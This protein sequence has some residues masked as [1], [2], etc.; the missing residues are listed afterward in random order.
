VALF[1][2]QLEAAECPPVV[3]LQEIDPRLL[4]LLRDE[5]PARCESAYEIVWH[6]DEGIDRELVLTTYEVVDQR[7]MRLAGPLRSAYRVRLRAPIGEIVLVVTHLASSDNTP[8]SRRWCPPP[9]DLGARI[10]VCQARQV[11]DLADEGD[12]RRRFTAVAGDLNDVATSDALGVFLDRGFVDTH[13]AAGNVECDPATGISCTS[14]RAD[15]DLSDLTNRESR[16]SERIDYVLLRA[17]DDCQPVFDPDGDP[18]GD[19][20]PT[21]VFAAS[22]ATGDL[23]FPSDH[24]AVA[25]DVRCGGRGARP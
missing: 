15:Q 10:R 25:L 3:A 1:L 6:G 16:Q 22:P 13:L 5:V 9:C 8:C 24:T 7:L 20:V 21:G 17:P 19:G 11:A 18:D 14:G 12:G 23:A 2:D 4:G